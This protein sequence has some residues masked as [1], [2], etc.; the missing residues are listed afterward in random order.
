MG[1][2][3]KE[4]PPKEITKFQKLQR[5]FQSTTF[6]ALLVFEAAMSHSGCAW[7]LGWPCNYSGYETCFHWIHLTHEALTRE[8]FLM[9]LPYQ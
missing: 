7:A 9:F 8:D 6:D 4:A 3:E 2:A 1:E 5:F